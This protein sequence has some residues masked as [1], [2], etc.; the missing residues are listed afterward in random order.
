[1]IKHFFIAVFAFMLLPNL[2]AAQDSSNQIASSEVKTVTKADE[3]KKQ[4]LEKYSWLEKYVNENCS[5]TKISELS[6]AG[7]GHS[8]ILLEQETTSKLLD[9]KGNT[10]CT[11]S[12]KLNCMEF[13]KFKETGL[14]WKCK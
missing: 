9:A 3:E 2:G 7:G 5:N 4:L 10:Y 14:S 8:Y 13:Y 11:N 6:S 1:M 12:A